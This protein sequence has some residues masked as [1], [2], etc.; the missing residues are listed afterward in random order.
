MN[1]V[2]KAIDSSDGIESYFYF[3]GKGGE[4]IITTTGEVDEDVIAYF[5]E[6]G[7]DWPEEADSRSRMLNPV[8]I[9]E[10]K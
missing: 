3:D 7:T 8:L 2:F 4:T 6:N 5:K 9:A 1:E 10:W